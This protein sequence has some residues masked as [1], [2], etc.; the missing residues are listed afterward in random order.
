MRI[1]QV[2]TDTDRRGAQIFATQLQEAMH[3]R[4]HEVETIAL[5][6]GTVG[7]L[8]IDVLD[9]R[10]PS[11]K[12]LGRLRRQMS[13]FDVTI[14]HGSSTGPACAM[15]G[16]GAGRP[17]V[18]RQVSDSYF[19]APTPAKRARVRTYL[20]RAAVVVALSQYNRS[21]LVQ[22][23]GVDREQI[24]VIPNAVPANEF[25]PATP[26]AR[27]AARE[28]L[29]V[30]E[31]PVVLFIGALVP[32]K[33]ADLA[34]WSL[35]EIAAAHLV[36]AGSGDEAEH[37]ERLSAALAPGRV[38]FVGTASDALSLY[39][40][41]DV[42]VLPSRGGDAMPAVIIEAGL[43]GLPVISTRIGAI[44]EMIV[45][46]ES[47]FVV[48]SD[49]L[50]ALEAAT[51]LLVSHPAMRRSMGAAARKRCLELYDIGPVAEQ[52]EAVLGKAV[53]GKP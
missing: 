19:W 22:R 25:G 9:Q 45:N 11:A 27:H 43:C 24:V 41:A 6:P 12:V 53:G 44:P 46:G 40:A 16:L 42:V 50:S 17:F 48:S 3:T 29:D 8:D 10:W 7:G 51:A 52:W 5:A 49:D 18:Y 30:G 32:E 20:A 36:V 31:A 21:L 34:V 13:R 38:H 14:A 26:D 4:G 28:A 1:L 2:V 33:G 39:Q 15:A 37:L 47:G 35:R 23:I